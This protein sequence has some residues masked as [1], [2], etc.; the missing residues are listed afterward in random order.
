MVGL[1]GRVA[2][3][4]GAG[5]SLWRVGQPAWRHMLG[6]A[7]GRL[8]LTLSALC[9]DVLSSR[10]TQLTRPG[11]LPAYRLTDELGG[12]AMTTVTAQDRT[13][14]VG[15][16]VPREFTIPPVPEHTTPVR[17]GRLIVGVEYRVLDDTVM[18]ASY[19]PDQMR[20]INESKPEKGFAE[21]GVS[22]HIIDGLTGEELI[23]FDCFATDPHYHYLPDK[24]WQYVIA[25]D[26]H[27]GGDFYDFTLA[28]LRSR[29]PDMLRFA[30]A[31]ELADEVAGL[32]MNAIADEVDYA[33]KSSGAGV[34]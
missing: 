29:L 31:G 7:S 17:A 15:N 11:A 22:L 32:D 1:P 23:R 2:I 26:S 5:P 4:T 34:H 19:T 20:V 12:I 24:D 6:R 13:N 28:A 14:P 18:S 3:V 30:G 27:A 21:E 16:R 25:F 33:A 9:M 8:I 10:G